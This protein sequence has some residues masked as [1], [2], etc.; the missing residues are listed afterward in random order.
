[1]VCNVYNFLSK[2]SING[3]SKPLL[4]FRYCLRTVV[5][6]E[7]K[8]NQRIDQL[9]DLKQVEVEAGSEN[10]SKEFPF[11]IFLILFNGI[12]EPSEHLLN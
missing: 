2:W 5:N 4:A 7:F 1:M 10:L 11:K 3:Q 12:L 6:Y 8:L 9:I